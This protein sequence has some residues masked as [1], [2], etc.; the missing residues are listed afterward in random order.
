MAHGAAF[1]RRADRDAQRSCRGSSPF[2]RTLVPA[3]QA[4]RALPWESVEAA[5]PLGGTVPMQL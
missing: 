2:T 1:P 3:A 4:R 5:A